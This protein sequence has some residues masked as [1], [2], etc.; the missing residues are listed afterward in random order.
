M[1]GYEFVRYPAQLRFPCER[2]VMLQDSLYFLAICAIVSG[3]VL[4]SVLGTWLLRSTAQVGGPPNPL[5]RLPLVPEVRGAASEVVA[6]CCQ[7]VVAMA[8]VV[9]HLVALIGSPLLDT[10]FATDAMGAVRDHG[11]WGIVAPEVPHT[12]A[13]ECFRR[14]H[15]P[16]SRS[17]CC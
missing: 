17:S 16:E 6:A 1:I 2:A 15:K 7:V 10:I 3:D 5:P 12:L 9:R 4:R 13:L 11:G 8:D 14:A